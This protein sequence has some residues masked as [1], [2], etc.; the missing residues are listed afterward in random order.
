MRADGSSGRIRHR[1]EGGIFTFSIKW[2]GKLKFK[3]EF[4]TGHELHMDEPP[5]HPLSEGAG[6]N[7]TRL[8]AASIAGCLIASLAYC[9]MIHRVE[10]EDISA[11]VSGTVARNE[12]GFLRVKEVNVTLRP[13]IKEKYRHKLERCI[14]IFEKYCTVTE[15]VRAGIPVRVQV[16]PLLD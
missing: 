15:S 12:E 6:V 3:V 16:D 14:G 9:L 10:I 5:H 1:Y 11:E 8:L 13:R 2:A 4:D 7:A